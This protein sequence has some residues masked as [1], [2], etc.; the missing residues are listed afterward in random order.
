M[1]PQIDCHPSGCRAYLYNCT[2]QRPM[3]ILAP[4]APWSRRGNQCR[5]LC[6]D[7][8]LDPR[9]HFP[10]LLRTISSAELASRVPILGSLDRHHRPLSFFRRM[11]YCKARTPLFLEQVICH[12]AAQ[13]NMFHLWRIENAS[14]NCQAR[15]FPPSNRGKAWRSHLIFYCRWTRS[16]VAPPFMRLRAAGDNGLPC[17]VGDG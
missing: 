7:P 9:L 10:T 15:V 3:L 1:S 5:S 14:W 17:C 4:L 16:G 6:F 11:R 2:V 12:G 13:T 8:G